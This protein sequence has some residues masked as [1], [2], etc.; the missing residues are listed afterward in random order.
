MTQLRTVDTAQLANLSRALV[1]FDR[2]FNN[3]FANVNG[4]YPPHNIVKYND[5]HYG[6]EV[7]VAGFSK[8]EITVEVDQDQLYITGKKAS[9]SEGVE[10]LHRGL[11]ARDF[12]QTFTLAEYMEV[13]GAEVKDGMLKIEIERIIP[14]ALKP[15]Q[16]KIK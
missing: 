11:A 2:Y 9:V 8:E 1:G 13:R 10:Y 3:Q 14:E 16:I 7:A 15:R 12:E 5:T 6:I 4:N